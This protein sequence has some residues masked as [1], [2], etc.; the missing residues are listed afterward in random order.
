MKELNIDFDE[1]P[2]ECPYEAL[3]NATS[4][5]SLDSLASGRSSDRDSVNREAEM[6]SVKVTGVRPV[7]SLM[8]VVCFLF[9]ENSLGYISRPVHAPLCSKLIA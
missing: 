3:Y 4:C 7:C 2:E 6:T 1:K 8:C 9:T 5:H